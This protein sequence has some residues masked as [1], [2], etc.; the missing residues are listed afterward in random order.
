MFIKSLFATTTALAL[1]AGASF[2]GGAVAPVIEVAPIMIDEAPVLGAWEGAYVG[3]SLGYSFGG[4]DE[5]GFDLLENGNE[6]GRATDLGKIELNG[7]TAGLHA[8]YRWQRGNWVFGPELGIEGGSVDDAITLTDGFDSVEVESQLNYLV[9]LVMKTGYE[10]QPGTLVYGTFGAAHGDFD[11]TLSGDGGSVTEGFS[12]TGIAA[13]LGVERM[14]NER[15][16]MFAEYQYRDLGKE[17]VDFV[18]G[19]DTL[20]TRATPRHSNVKFGVNYKF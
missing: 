17:T 20:S 9:T 13:G 4:N 18:D 1:G 10:V 6:A 2:A 15:M 16:S 12:T 8:G 11:Y 5:V 19:T 7:V 14:I 3:G